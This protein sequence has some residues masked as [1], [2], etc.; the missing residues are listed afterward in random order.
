MEQKIVPPKASYD[1]P[2]DALMF[3]KTPEL[4]RKAAVALVRVVLGEEAIERPLDETLREVCR[5]IRPSSDPNEQARYES[6]FVELVMGPRPGAGQR[7]A[8]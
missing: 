2:Y 3:A 7:I 6:E 8:A 5:E 1:V 4:A